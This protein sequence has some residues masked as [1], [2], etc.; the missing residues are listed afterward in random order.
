VT[1]LAVTGTAEVDGQVVTATATARLAAEHR[2]P[3]G[4]I[5]A[6]IARLRV[7]AEQAERHLAAIRRDL[8]ELI[9]GEHREGSRM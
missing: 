8:E 6:E 4:L 1:V 5:E 9:H 2:G 3:G 7:L